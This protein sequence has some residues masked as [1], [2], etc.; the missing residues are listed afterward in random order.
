MDSILEL[1]RQL[2]SQ[3]LK[4]QELKQPWGSQGHEGMYCLYFV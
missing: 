2:N 1:K 4:G 3:A